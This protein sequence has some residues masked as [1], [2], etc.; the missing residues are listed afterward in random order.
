[1][2]T[3]I[4]HATFGSISILVSFALIGL[5]NAVHAQGVSSSEP[6][7]AVVLNS[8]EATVS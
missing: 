8:G 6:K 1:M 2:Q 7:L 4:R 3:Y 5:A